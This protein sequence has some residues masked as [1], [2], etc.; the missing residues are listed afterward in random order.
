MRISR[1][2]L[3]RGAVRIV[4]SHEVDDLALFLIEI[5]VDCILVL[6]VNLIHASKLASPHWF[7]TVP[8]VL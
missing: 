6:P 3:P 5:I 7:R 1:E 4:T 8:D 2:R